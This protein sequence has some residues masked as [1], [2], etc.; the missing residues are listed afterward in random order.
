MSV[1]VQNNMSNTHSKYKANKKKTLIICSTTKFRWFFFVLVETVS[2][3]IVTIIIIFVFSLRHTSMCA[4]IEWLLAKLTVC[5][6]RLKS[7]YKCILKYCRMPTT[8]KDRYNNITYTYI[9]GWCKMLEKWRCARVLKLTGAYNANNRSNNGKEKET[10]TQ[11]RA[12]K[13]YLGNHRHKEQ[14]T[15]K[16]IHKKKQKTKRKERRLNYSIER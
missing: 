13:I 5:I 1:C 9:F 6:I 8:T 3:F 14:P 10:I 7:L 12:T 15:H 11:R 16:H 4:R 2:S